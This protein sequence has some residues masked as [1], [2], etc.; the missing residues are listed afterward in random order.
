M[1]RGPRP[2]PGRA[3]CCGHLFRFL[4]G[5]VVERVSVQGLQEGTVQVPAGLHELPRQA[6]LLLQHVVERQHGRAVSCQGCTRSVS[7][8][9]PPAPHHGCPPPPAGGA[10]PRLWAHVL[11]SA[12][13]QPRGDAFW[14]VPPPEVPKAPPIPPGRL[15]PGVSELLSARWRVTRESHMWDAQRPGRDASLN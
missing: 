5:V 6:Q 8:G 15:Y 12:P 14:K 7:L 9:R 3:V 4:Q 2:L 13:V 1:R 10:G 11:G